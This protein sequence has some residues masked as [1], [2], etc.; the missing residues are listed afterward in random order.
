MKIFPISKRASLMPGDRVKIKE[1]DD[2]TAWVSILLVR[3]DL[4]V[5]QYDDGEAQS[6]SLNALKSQIIDKSVP[7]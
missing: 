1:W 4:V 3:D 2:S 5:I 6:M 7:N